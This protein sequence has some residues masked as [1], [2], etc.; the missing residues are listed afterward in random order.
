MVT[1]P[2]YEASATE[3]AAAAPVPKAGG[4]RRR[5]KLSIWN[6]DIARDVEKSKQEHKISRDARSQDCLDQ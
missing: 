5:N 4:H 2:L 1:A 3:S 6:E